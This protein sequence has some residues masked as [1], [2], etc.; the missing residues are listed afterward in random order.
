MVTVWGLASPGE[1]T[2]VILF[3]VCTSLGGL[4]T[5][6]RAAKFALAKCSGEQHVLETFLCYGA[7]RRRDETYA[8]KQA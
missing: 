4:S 5:T 1:G 3:L 7:L 8:H 2:Y 6:E